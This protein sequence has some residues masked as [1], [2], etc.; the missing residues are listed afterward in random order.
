MIN[1]DMKLELDN[2]VR[3][4]HMA[5]YYYKECGFDAHFLFDSLRKHATSHHYNFDVASEFAFLQNYDLA[6]TFKFNIE[7]NH[8]T[9]AGYTFEHELHYARINN[10][11]G[12]VDANQGHPLLGWDTDEFPTDLYA[13]TLAMYEILKKG[14]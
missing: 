3:C 7:A 10:M 12:S 11:L 4:Y 5:K 2:L 1:T 6:D 13:T 14:E 9:L 8:A